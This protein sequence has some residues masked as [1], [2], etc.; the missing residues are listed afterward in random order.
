[1]ARDIL[2]A[3]ARTDNEFDLNRLRGLLKVATS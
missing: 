1:M 3:L 2:R